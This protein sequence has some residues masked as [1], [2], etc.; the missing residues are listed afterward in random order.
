MLLINN[1]V[2]VLKFSKMDEKKIK[3][4]VNVSKE[5]V[6]LKVSKNLMDSGFNQDK[7]DFLESLIKKNK[8]FIDLMYLDDEFGVQ[9]TFNRVTVLP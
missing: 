4:E 9:L 3:I 5:K 8:G 6:Q 2:D 7:F 1:F